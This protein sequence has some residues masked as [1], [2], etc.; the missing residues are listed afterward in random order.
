MTESEGCSPV[1]QGCLF[2]D[3]EDESKK[4]NCHFRCKHGKRLTWRTA[5]LVLGLSISEEPGSRELAE[6]LMKWRKQ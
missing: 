5:R 3:V 1:E 4:K 6:R 2:S